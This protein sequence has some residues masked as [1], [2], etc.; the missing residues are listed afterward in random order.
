[1]GGIYGVGYVDMDGQL[2]SLAFVKNKKFAT[3]MQS[4]NSSFHEMEFLVC[5]GPEFGIHFNSIKGIKQ[6]K[7]LKLF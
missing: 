2:F 1:M 7:D 5:K 6:T 3:Y 4:R